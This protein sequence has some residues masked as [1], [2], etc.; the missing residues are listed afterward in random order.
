MVIFN[1]FSGPVPTDETAVWRFMDFV[2]FVSILQKKQ[3]FFA[4]PECF[5]DPFEGVMPQAV[6]DLYTEEGAS[7]TTSRRF[8]Q[9]LEAR[10]GVTEVPRGTRRFQHALFC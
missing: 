2:S 1:V 8:G 4:S 3:L 9:A 10:D 7:Q 5:E 6:A